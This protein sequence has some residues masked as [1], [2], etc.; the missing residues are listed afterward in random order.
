MSEFAKP[1]LSPVQISLDVST[2]S[3][4]PSGPTLTRRLLDLKGCFKNTEAWQREVEKS[5]PIVYQVISSVVP[6]TARELPQSITTIFAGDCAG[7]L[8]MTKGHQHPDPQGEIYYG[9][10]GQGGIILF[11]GKKSAWVE[12][13]PGK[14][15]YIPPGWAHRSINTGKS[16][17]KFLA[18]YPGCAGHDYQWVLDN[19]MGL[20][21]FKNNNNF[22]L[23]EF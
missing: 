10:E 3:L 9:L 12:I 6:E 13:T 21:A 8:Y 11:D 20:R 7:E 2:G 15:G 22:E 4:S 18:V 16:D 17:Y 23:S 19:G 14:I 5:N 1:P